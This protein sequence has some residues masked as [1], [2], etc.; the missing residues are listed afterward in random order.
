MRLF[1][2]TWGWLALE[3]RNEASHQPAARI[4]RERRRFRGSIVTSDFVLDETITRLF[5]HKPFDESSRFLDGILRSAAA[6]VIA[7]ERV[8]EARFNG[9]LALRGRFR[10]KPRI[11]FTD[12][13]TMVILQELKCTDVL[14]ADAH[15]LQVGLGFRILPWS[16][17]SHG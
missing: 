10:D 9:A 4:Y 6:G 3:D 8:S 2:D 7:I 16:E 5:R 11:S 17:G 14:S 1:V 15:F 12:L 13:T